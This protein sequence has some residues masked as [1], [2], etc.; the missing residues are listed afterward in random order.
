MTYQIQNKEIE[1]YGNNYDCQIYSKVR[2]FL[3]FLTFNTFKEHLTNRTIDII[4]E[5]FFGHIINS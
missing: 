1:G 5:F 3:H 4:K 2:T